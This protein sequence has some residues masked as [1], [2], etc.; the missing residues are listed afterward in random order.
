[1]ITIPNPDAWVP[2]KLQPDIKHFLLFCWCSLVLR[3]S[4]CSKDSFHASPCRAPSWLQP[5][6]PGEGDVYTYPFLPRR[7]KRTTLK[8]QKVHTKP[9]LYLA[10][11]SCF[12]S[13]FLLWDALFCCCKVSVS[14]PRIDRW[15]FAVEWFNHHNSKRV[16]FMKYLTFAPKLVTNKWVD[17]W[18]QSITTKNIFQQMEILVN[19]ATRKKDLLCTRVF[20]KRTK[21]RLVTSLPARKSAKQLGS[22]EKPRSA[23]LIN[24]V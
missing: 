7:L 4:T 24:V 19:R 1:M 23:N 3:L 10:F 9:T 22:E 18:S 17:V 11:S 6:P 8:G 15:G 21:L 20:G 14:F 2:Q 12:Q 16:I 13:G 5:P